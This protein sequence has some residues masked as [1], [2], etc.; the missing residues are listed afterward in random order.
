VAPAPYKYTAA[1]TGIEIRWTVPES[2][3]SVISD[4]KVYW[5]AGLSNF[6]LL[7]TSS[8]FLSFTATSVHGVVGGT[9]YSFKVSAVNDVGE[10]P[11]SDSVSI[12]AATV[13]ETPVIPTLVSQSQTEIVVSWVAPADGGSPLLDFLV[14]SDGATGTFS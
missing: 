5:D 13:P 1:T 11:L 3:G 7:G 12:I 2:G 9:A 10:G 6:V 4:Y 14:F 8:G